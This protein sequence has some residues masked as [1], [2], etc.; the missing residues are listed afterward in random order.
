MVFSTRIRL[1]RNVEGFPF[2]G[3][4]PPDKRTELERRLQHWIHEVQV[5]DQVHYCNLHG[6]SGLE[7]QIL[8]ERHLISPELVKGSGD[9]GVTFAPSEL[10]SLMTNEEDHIRIQVIRSGLSLKE[11]YEAARNLDH[12]L[13]E[14]VPFSFH[15][16]Y[17]YL[18]ACPT[19]VGSAM[20]VSVMMHLPA[21]VLAD[22][23][24]KVFQ[25][26]SKVN[27]TVRGFYGEGTKALGDV[28]QISNQHTLGRSEEQ[29]L[30]TIQR[31]VPKIVEYERGVRT[32]LVNES[33]IMLE[34]KVWRSIGM[35][36][37]ARKLSSA[38]A[39]D[40]L[41]AV[42]LGINLKLVPQITLPEVNELFV[43]TQPGHLQAMRGGELPEGD[44]D[45]A[46]AAFLRDRLQP[47]AN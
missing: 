12:R 2:P 11:A 33:R 21:L 4:I 40:L 16:R 29:I 26:A 25:A 23:M 8:M 42:R 37:Y 7:K 47:E 22:Q 24:D 14:R 35:L 19:N 43:I 36:R 6:M 31:I 39:M 30:E 28:I 9:R 38:E 17:G 46:R 10:V 27:L 34:D 20:R 44:R 15:P 45:V 32:R 3:R 13:E 41:S 5:A 1:A 18:T